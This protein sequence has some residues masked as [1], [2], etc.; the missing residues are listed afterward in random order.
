MTSLFDKPKLFSI[1]IP[2]YNRAN[3]IIKTLESILKQT[4]IHWECIIIDDGSTDNTNE[5]IQRYLNKD[6]RF[7]YYNRPSCRA[8]GPN[9][10]RNYGFEKCTGD[11]VQ[12]FDS[13]DLYNPL[14]LEL[15]VARMN[16]VADVVVGQL[17]F[18]NFETGA[19][20]KK[21][22]IISDNIIEDYFIGKIA[23]F[24]CG[25]LWKRSFLEQ[26]NCLFDE[27]LSNLDDW[28]FNL[29]MLYEKPIVKY[30]NKPIIQYRCHQNSLS[31]ELEKLNFKEIQSEFNAREKH[32]LLLSQN[33]MADLKVLNKF[34]KNRYKYF[35]RETLIQNHSKKTYFLMKLLQ[36]ELFL[37]DIYGMLKTASGF[38]VFSLFKKG[39]SLLK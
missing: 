28:D 13:D 19:T 14:A 34:I 26:Q 5:V 8:K 27:A 31:S 10:C 11:F 39:Y 24:V 33:K 32:L 36:S 20:I 4:Y 9:A 1:I 29:R 35:F 17:E 22:N 2:T 3:V 18:V 7:Q 12:W 38:I 30:I 25:P 15:Y 16:E 23:Y 21:S 37:F 6:V